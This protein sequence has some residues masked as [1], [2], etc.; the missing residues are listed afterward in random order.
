MWAYYSTKDIETFVGRIL[1]TEHTEKKRHGQE[2]HKIKGEG[3]TN[4]SKGN[5]IY[6]NEY[7]TGVSERLFSLSLVIR[8][9]FFFWEANGKTAI[10]PDM[11]WNG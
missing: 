7:I 8:V 9:L 4:G 6:Y 5:E 11:E 2:T 3:D 1:P 10:F